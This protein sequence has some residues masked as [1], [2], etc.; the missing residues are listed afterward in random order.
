MVRINRINRIV[1]RS[2]RRRGT[3][4]SNKDAESRGMQH[5]DAMGRPFNTEAQRRRGT[6]GRDEYNTQKN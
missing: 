1:L 2:K 5:K 3:W 4:D 6:E